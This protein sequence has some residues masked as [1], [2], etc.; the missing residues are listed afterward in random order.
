MKLNETIKQNKTHND[1]VNHWNNISELFH[2]IY[3]IAVQFF[4]FI[5]E[6]KFTH[7]RISFSNY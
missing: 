5:I 1:E 3:S 4:T 2:V 6:A 7:L